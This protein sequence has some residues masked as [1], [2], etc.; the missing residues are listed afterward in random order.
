MSGSVT[1][2]INMIGSNVGQSMG[3]TEVTIVGLLIA[4]IGTLSSAV[5][6]LY[7]TASNQLT[8]EIA[9]VDKKLEECERDRND[10]WRDQRS[11]WS[12]VTH[13]FDMTPDEA[14]QEIKTEQKKADDKQ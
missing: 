5:A 2:I 4:A 8:R 12:W 6:Y 13:K 10:L 1:D 9:R 3:G 11:L 14:K 7:H